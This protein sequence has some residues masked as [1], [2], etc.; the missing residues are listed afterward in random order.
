MQRQ[1]KL[2]GPLLDKNGEL[3]DKGYAKCLV[4]D[5]DRKA[6]KAKKHRIKEWDYYLI[7]DDNY[8]VALTIDDNSYMG[9]VSVSLIDFKNKREKTI[10][11]MQWLT[12]GKRNFPSSSVDGD[13][14]YDNKKKNKRV[15]VAFYN[16]NGKRTLEVIF[17]KFHNKETFTCFV[18]LTEEPRDSMVI[19]TPF[20]E[21]K[22]A[23]YYN[24]KIVGFKVDGFFK[25][26]DFKY[27]FEKEQ[28]RGILDWGRG[29][30]TYKNTWYWGAGTRKVDGHEVGFNIGYGFGD[31]SRAS[32]NVIFYDGR[33]H[34]LDQVSFNIPQ[35]EKGNYLYT[36]PWT[37]T[38]ND[39]RFEMEFKPI[40]NRASKTDVGIICSDQNQV[41]GLF[42]G[43]MVLD[44]GTKVEIKDFLGFAERVFNKW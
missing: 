17:N 28:T 27:R 13:V 10:S 19:I 38:S 40:I 9:L 43:T 25:L 6:I 41:F 42:T 14:I 21:D 33:L 44:D 39:N 22:K 23:F 36:N 29:V 7:Y 18:E 2:R 31:T 15:K 30:W 11:P 3:I 26:G 1:V 16:K 12:F 35:D 4:K 32:E 5:Y 8:A 37:F 34:K 20:K 24:Q